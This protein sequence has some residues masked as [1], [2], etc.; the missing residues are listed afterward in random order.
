LKPRDRRNSE[1]IGPAAESDEAGST[2]KP[3]TRAIVLLP[4]RP[5]EGRGVLQRSSAGRLAEAVGL[6][7]AIR[8]DVA[9]ALVV[10]LRKPS[11]GTLLGEGK[12]EEIAALVR[13]HAAELVIVDD[14]LSPVQQRNLE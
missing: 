6:A 14:P 5:A 4:E 7:E 1:A 11:P 8:L 13:V 3:P 9:A 12:V 2:R 10:P